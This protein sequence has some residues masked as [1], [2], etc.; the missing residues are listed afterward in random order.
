MGILNLLLSPFIFVF[1]LLYFF[2][3]YAKEFH[4][5]PTSLAS[6]TFTPLARWKF[7]EF[8]EL[9]HQ[10]TTRLSAAYGPAT[11][12]MK[13]FPQEKLAIVARFVAFTSG[14]LAVSL[15]FLSILD[16]NILLN[17]QITPGRS[18]L[19]WMGVLG[20]IWSA[21]KS[22]I[23]DTHAVYAPETFFTQVVDKTHHFPKHW[24]TASAFAVY[25]E[26]G[27]LFEYRL[28]HFF[29]EMIAV[30]TAPFILCFRLPQCAPQI[31]DFFREFTVHVDGLGLV[32][33]F[34]VFD[35]RKYHQR[36]RES[37]DRQKMEQSLVDFQ[38]NF[39]QW[40]PPADATNDDTAQQQ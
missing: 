9:K 30:V 18:V 40:K 28:L 21:A 3:K 34:A 13:Q 38:R 4:H 15:T 37:I 23:P 8:N 29:H 5:D 39:P 11:R 27:S 19:W 24:Q 10:F 22:L 31:L 14:S 36:H 20:L 2:F 33:S 17:F 6:R 26:F 7:R 25:H 32:C 1:L 35:F 16:D 12:Y